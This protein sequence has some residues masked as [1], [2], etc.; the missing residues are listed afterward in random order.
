MSLG[1]EQLRLDLPVFAKPYKW[2]YVRTVD[3]CW[4]D[5]HMH[6][7]GSSSGSCVPVVPSGWSGLQ[8]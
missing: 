8:P 3:V 6:L 4:P 1:A 7:H 5:E 2:F